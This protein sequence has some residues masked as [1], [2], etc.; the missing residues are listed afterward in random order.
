[1]SYL[2]LYNSEQTK[3]HY[4]IELLMLRRLKTIYLYVNYLN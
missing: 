2:K 4:K 1:M 3:D